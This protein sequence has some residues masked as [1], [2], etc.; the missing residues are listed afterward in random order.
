[1][2]HVTL[3][4]VIGIALFLLGLVLMFQ[5]QPTSS[6]RAIAAL[7]VAGGLASGVVSIWVSRINRNNK[8]DY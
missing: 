1:M 5:Y 8:L 4:A 7:L 2:R 6:L 3:F